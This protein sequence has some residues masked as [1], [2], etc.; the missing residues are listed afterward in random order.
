MNELALGG[1]GGVAA[2]AAPA[3]HAD[4]DPAAVSDL[5]EGGGLEVAHLLGA[6]EG[7][8]DPERRPVETEIDDDDVTA[9]DE[10]DVDHDDSDSDYDAKTEVGAVLG[11]FLSRPG[12]D[13]LKTEKSQTV[14]YSSEK[15]GPP[16]MQE[17]ESPPISSTIN[18]ERNPYPGGRDTPPE[19]MTTKP[20]AKSKGDSGSG[21]PRPHSEVVKEFLAKTESGPEG[22]SGEKEKAQ[23]YSGKPKPH[24][25]VLDEFLAKTKGSVNKPTRTHSDVVNEFL[26]EHKT[27]QAN[28]PIV[29]PE[30]KISPNTDK[31]Q[32][33]SH[34]QVV[35]QLQ[36]KISN[37]LG[38]NKDTNEEERPP[39]PHSQIVQELKAQSQ[40]KS[41]H[42]DGEKKANKDKGP[43]GPFPHSVVPH[44]QVVKQ[45][46]KGKNPDDASVQIVWQRTKDNKDKG[47]IG[48]LPHSVVPHSQV[49]KQFLEGKNQDKSDGKKADKVKGP[50]GLAGQ[51]IPHSQVVQRLKAQGI[52]MSEKEGTVPHSKIVQEVQKDLLVQK[53]LAEHPENAELKQVLK[54]DGEKVLE[55]VAFKST[56]DT[57][58]SDIKLSLKE[59][60][61]STTK[62]PPPLLTIDDHR[63]KP[64]DE[65]LA[66]SRPQPL[67]H[68]IKYSAQKVDQ[69][70][71]TLK[72]IVGAALNDEGDK[73]LQVDTDEPKI[74]KPRPEAPFAKKTTADSKKSNRPTVKPTKKPNRRK[75]GSGII[76]KNS[77]KKINKHRL[78]GLK[79]KLSTTTKRPKPLFMTTQKWVSMSRPIWPARTTAT[80]LRTTTST[81]TTTTTTTTTAATTRIELEVSADDDPGMLSRMV[82]MVDSFKNS[83]FNFF[84]F[85]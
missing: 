34:A 15:P 65:I 59:K 72:D 31:Q 84:N 74:S 14:A 85:G 30:T 60:F 48:H 29:E 18:T 76:N 46:L 68:A 52:K 54:K 55:K 49:V 32:P 36:A 2:A 20:S 8:G 5:G 21:D 77:K 79:E 11:M 43:I 63:R 64:L 7:Q 61:S 1:T 80:R 50:N 9:S 73:K 42:V 51:S 25:Q 41:D 16:L 22:G 82:G 27:T 37:K 67:Y 26:K 33:L 70:V 6:V 40:P 45:F 44:A 24:S 66:N 28:S 56:S 3:V 10:Q 83:F 78:G 71:Q 75:A 19:T 57:F 53:L 38:Q 81:T 39:V 47:P 23:V 62:R 17:F 58:G 12:I 4:Q 69:Q 35:K 13:D